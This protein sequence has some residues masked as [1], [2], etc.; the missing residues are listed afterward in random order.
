ME[1]GI[2]LLNPVHTL[3][4]S[5]E[6]IFKFKILGIY[7]G[8]TIVTV[9]AFRYM[10]PIAAPFVI[11]VLVAAIIER[12][13]A[14]FEQKFK[15][16]RT[17]GAVVMIVLI[18][19]VLGAAVYFGGRLLVKQIKN[20]M[21]NYESY[22]NRF[23]NIAND[24]CCR[25]DKAF[26]LK[27]GTSFAYLSEQADKTVSRISDGAMSSVMNRSV[28][29]ISGF[30]ML[31]TG[32]AITIMGT[33]FLSKDMS[34][35]RD[36]VRKNIF[37]E[38]LIYIGGRLKEV[39]GTYFKTELIIMAI[40]S[41]ICTLGLFLMKNPYAFL[42]GIFIGL[43][44]ALPILGTGTIF[45]PWAIILLLLK[46]FKK[47]VF[48]FLIYIICYYSRAFLE[49]KLMGNKLDASP[50]LMLFAIYVGLKLFG[51]LGVFTGPIALILIKEISSM[52]IKDLIQ[53]G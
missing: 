40:T 38:E 36:G 22:V 42:L 24:C 19:V 8:V 46:D 45:I 29:L 53:E 3:T 51:I 17:I 15:V 5:R 31:F 18:F 47:A 21:E 39:L 16:K 52:L 28:N 23:S 41:G 20:L 4:M 11:A 35:V 26:S 30:T 12:P 13:V 48:I 7:T 32:I 49:P 9:F 27:T 14:Y 25:I 1:Y 33:I 10:L 50:V 6:Y 43:V 34:R 2:N 37:G 44:D